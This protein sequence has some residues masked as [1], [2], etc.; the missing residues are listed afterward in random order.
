MKMSENL[1]TETFSVTNSKILS[2]IEEN[3]EEFNYSVVS[4][5]NHIEQSST[6]KT[7]LTESDSNSLEMTKSFYNM[8]V[9]MNLI[10]AHLDNYDTGI[11]VLGV[12]GRDFSTNRIYW[13]NTE[14]ELADHEITLNSLEN[15][16]RL[17][18][19]Y[20]DLY[21]EELIKPAIIASRALSDRKSGEIYGVLYIAMQE[22]DFR[23]FYTS[24]TSE[25]NNV[26][27][28]NGA[29]TIVSSNNAELIGRDEQVLLKHAKEIDEL[30]LNYKNVEFLDREQIVLAE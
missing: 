19:H 3:V 17:S 25:G 9:Q 4:T 13:P 30:N 10:R 1:F 7:F 14:K 18:Y 24:Y 5:V 29:G 16:K 20:D 6:V 2:Q 23:Q 26:A 12:N 8:S 22:L 27:I 28:I 15:P 11:T 21:T